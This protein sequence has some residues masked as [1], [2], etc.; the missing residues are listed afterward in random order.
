MG[1]QKRFCDAASEK[2]YDYIPDEM[3]H[4]FLLLSSCDSK[5]NYP[6]ISSRTGKSYPKILLSVQHKWRFSEAVISA[7]FGA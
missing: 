2:P 5:M 1:V 4:D 7:I 3:K 6:E